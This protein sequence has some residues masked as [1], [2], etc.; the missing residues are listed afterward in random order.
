MQLK[1]SQIRRCWAVIFGCLLSCPATAC[2]ELLYFAT[3]QFVAYEGQTINGVLYRSSTAFGQVTRCIL[4]STNVIGIAPVNV[5]TDVTGLAG[6]GNPCYQPPYN[7]VPASFASGS[8]TANFAIG[9]VDNSLVQPERGA[10]LDVTFYGGNTNYIQ[11]AW[12]LL[13]DNDTPVTVGLGAGSVA[14]GRT[15]QIYFD[16]ATNNVRAPMTVRFTLSG[17]ATLNS[18]YQISAPAPFTLVTGATHQLTIP[19]WYTQGQG[20]VSVLSDAVLEGAETITVR[21]E[22]NP[23]QYTMPATQ[24]VTMVVRDDYPVVSV[25]ATDNYA[26][27]AG[28]NCGVFTL[29]RSGNLT[30]PVTVQVSYTGTAVPGS[31]YLALPT[32]ITF[33]AG[34]T[35]TN[36]VVTPI[37]DGLIEE[38]ETVVLNLLTN[39]SYVLGLHTNA[40]VTIAGQGPHPRD[41]YPRAE[42][43]M[44]GSGPNLDTYSIVVPLDGL[45]G[46]R[47]ADVETNQFNSRYATA[48]HYNATNAGNQAYITNRIKFDTPI[49]SFGS[50]WGAPLYL[51][52]SYSLG[53][54]AG[55]QTADPLR[56]YTL[57]RSNVAMAG[58]VELKLPNPLIASDWSN[59]ATNAFARTTNGYG[60]TTTLRAAANMTWGTS[61]GPGWLLT[62]TAT[63]AATNYVYLVAAVGLYNNQLMVLNESG[64]GA[65]G[66][67]YELTFEPRPAWRAVFIDQ[68]HFQTEPLPPD[69]WNKTPDE[70]YH[71]GAPVTNIVALSPSACTTLDHSPELRGHPIL[72][73]FVADL[74]NDPLALANYVQNEIELADPIAYRDDGSVTTESVNCGGVNRSAL[75]VYLEGQGSPVEQC[76]LLIYLLRRAGYPAAYVFPPEGG[77]KML[78]TRLSA[79]LRTRINQAQDKQ[80]RLYTRNRLITVNYPWVAV[81]ISNQWVHLFPWI[82]DTAV[83][84]GLNLYDYL[85]AQYKDM[86]LWVRDYILGRSNIMSFATLADDTPGVIFPRWLDHHL[87]QSAPGVS[88]DD[89]GIRYVNRR[90][91]Y[92]T[93]SDFPR[94]T[95]VSNFCIG[96]ESLTAAGI[97]NVSPRLTNIFDTVQVELYSVN[98]PDKK[99]ATC[100]MRMADLHNR[101]FFITHTN[102]GDGRVHAILTLAPYRP[103]ATN[104]IGNFAPTDTALTNKQVLTLV[105]TNTDDELKLRLRHRRQ[106]AL[107]WET[108]LDPDR[109][110]LDLRSERQ[111]L[112]ERPLRKGDVGGI[113]LNAGRVTP[114]MLRVHAQELWNMERLLSTNAAA[115]N[116]ISVDVYQG[117]LVYLVGMSYYERAARFDLP[118]RRLFKVQNLS[119]MAMGLA[120][121]SVRR[122]PDGT[123][124]SG[125]IDPIWPNVDMF[126]QEVAAVGNGTVRLD[127]GWDRYAAKRNYFNLSIA[128]LSAQEHAILNLFFGQSNAV[129]TVKLLQ[130]AQSK[131]PAGGSNVVELHYHNYAAEGNKVYAGKPLKDHD[132]AI[133]SEVVENFERGSS[134]GF[135]VAWVTPGSQTTP[136]GSFSGMGALILGTSRF[137]ALIGNNLYGG[138]ADRL[139]YGAVSPPQLPQW[140]VRGDAQGNYYF[141]YA[142]PTPS[143]RS[144]APAATATFDLTS[145]CALLNNG[146]FYVNPY[147]VQQGQLTGWLLNNAPGTYQGMYDDMADVGTLGKPSFI[148]RVWGTIADPVDTMTGEFHVD[149]VDLTLPGP[150]PLQVRRNYS[151]HNLAANQLGYG[152]KL[153]YMP[154]LTIANT[155]NIIYA[156]EPDGSVLASGP[157]A[158]NL[159]APT[160]ALNPTL[161]NDTVNGI[162]SV[163]NYFNARLARLVTPTNTFYYLT[164]GD[165][166]LR[167]FT[168]MSFPLTNSAA[169]DRSRPYLTSWFD[170]R[171]NFY[172]FEYGTNPAAADYGQVRR[173]IS[174][175]GNIVRF[176][177]DPYGRIVEA[178]SL[179]GRRVQY[180]DDRFGDLVRVTLPDTS[181]IKYEYELKT[182]STNNLTNVYSTHLLIRELKPDGRVLRN[183]FDHMR[184]VTNQWA[185]VG[186]DL[187]LVRNASFIYTNNFNLT[188]LTAALTG[189]TTVLDY[190]NNPTTYFYTNSLLRRVRDPLGGEL[191]QEWYEAGE[192]TPPAYPRSLKKVTDKRGLVTEYKYDSRGN[193][194]NITVRGDLRGDGNTDT[195]AVTTTV[196]NAN[197]LPTLTV[198]AAGTTNLFFYTN[199]WLLAWVEIWPSNATPAQ[200]V[201]NVYEYA[202]VTNA[203]D[204]TASFGLRVSEIRA[205]GSPDAATNEWTYSSRGFPIRFVRYTGTTDPAVVLTNL[206]NYR[207]ELVQQTDA[208]GRITR[209]GYDPLGRP[210]L[211]ELFEPGRSIP[212]AWGYSYYNENGEL[213][214]SD[215]PRF[216]PEDY[217]W[218]DYDGAGRKTVEIR[219]LTR[220]RPDGTGVQAETGDNLYA[221]TFNEYDP[222]G[223]LIR[224]TDPV[225]NYTRKRYDALGQLIREEFYDAT[226]VLLATNGFRYNPAGDVTNVFNPLGRLTEKQYTSTGK[227][228]FQRN[229]DGSTNAWRYYPD[230]RVHCEIQ[231][232]GAYWEYAYDDANRRVIRVFRSAAGVPLA[233]NVSEYDRR[234]N[235]IK[236]IDGLGNVFTSVYDGLDRLKSATGPAI[237]TVNEDCGLIPGCGNFVTNVLQQATTN[238]YDAAGVWLTN[239]NALCEKTVTRYDALGRVI[240]TEIRTGANALVRETTIVYHT[241]HHGMTVTNGAGATAIVTTTYTDNDGRPLLEVSYPVADSLEFTS[242]YY[243]RAGRRVESAEFCKI[244][245]GPPLVW[246]ISYWEYDGLNRVTRETTRDYATTTYEYDPMGNVTKRTMPGGLSWHA[247]YNVAG[248]LLEEKNVGTGGAATRTNTYAYYPAGHRWAGLLQTRAD[249]RG[250][251]C[252]H[253]YDDWLRQ[254]T[255]AYTGPLPE[256]NLTTTWQY[257]LRGLLTN[258]VQLFANTNVSP[259]TVVR[260][261]YDPYGQMHTECI[262][263]GQTT[264]AGAAMAY[265]AAGRHSQLRLDTHSS[266]A[267]YSYG[268]RADGALV[269]VI[270]PAGTAVYTYDTAGLLTSRSIA[271]RTASVTARDGTGRPY[272]IRTTIGATTVLAESLSWYLNGQLAAHTLARADYT[273]ARAYDYA[274]LS[275]R[276]IQE[277]LNLSATV[278]WTNYF[279]YDNA[280][281]AGPGVLT[282]IGGSGHTSTAWTGSPDAFC[283]INFETNTVLRRTAYGTVNGPATVTATLD[284]QPVGI[285][286]LGTNGGQWRA[287]LALTPGA[288]QLVVTARH[289]SGQFTTN[290]VSWF[291]NNNTAGDRAQVYYDALGQPTLRVW[292]AAN[293][294][295]NRT[296]TLCWDVTG[297]LWKVIERDSANNGYDWQA[298][299]DAFGRRLQTLTVTV[300]NGVA[301]GAAPR[302]IFS[303]YDPLVEFLE[304][305]VQYDTGIIGQGTQTAWKLYGPDLSGRYGGL[306]GVGGLEAVKPGY[307]APVV[308]IADALGN[309]HKQFDTASGTL[310]LSSVRPTAYGA[311][312][313]REPVALGY[314]GT[315]LDNLAWRGRWKDITGLYWLGMRYYEPESGRWLSFDPVWNLADASGYSFCGGD[316]INRFDADGRVGKAVGDFVY[317]GGAAGYALREIGLYVER[318]E[319]TS[320]A[321]GWWTGLSSAFAY[322][323]AAASAPSTYVSGLRS[324]G[325]NVASYYQDFGLL[326]AASYALTSWNVG[327]VYSG[328]ANF[329]LRYETAG[330]PIGDWYERG[331]VISSGVAS[332]A[333]IAA[334]AL[335]GCGV[336]AEGSARPPVPAKFFARTRIEVEALMEQGF[337]R[338]EAFQHIRAFNA[339][340][341]EGFLFHFTDEIGGLGIIR[342]GE[343]QATQR[344]LGGPGVYTG[345]TPTPNFFQRYGSP[346]GWG[347]NPSSNVRIPI[348]VTPEIEAITRTP[349]LPRWTRIIGEG[350][351]MP[352]PRRNP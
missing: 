181:Q 139:N 173:M 207:G 261:S 11:Q 57:Y 184:R 137:A 150:M 237:V 154:F 149:E 211:R 183:E 3:N 325:Y 170:N 253:Y 258:S 169:W 16:R 336:P 213:T 153:N 44:R 120:K 284:G 178:Y 346:I 30:R 330:Q 1:A 256:H 187:R 112:V 335:G 190:T 162:G 224:V 198:D 337:S 201:T 79:L 49:A 342:S 68:P 296:Q 278:R 37:A 145:D 35:K 91:L 186:P 333:G 266:T 2:G 155:N 122:N 348:I 42:R 55:A 196:Y 81:Y 323:L 293:G 124:Y 56:I 25:G 36:L 260:R 295:T 135:V 141:T 134:E 265:D 108:A 93:W 9:V 104:S 98:N 350:E 270:G 340:E 223:N 329:D 129:S 113:C 41:A 132:P 24:A 232:N 73:Q 347:L 352:L 18:D 179:D 238:F 327:A 248:Q 34:Q 321:A 217:V 195:T 234:G 85:P 109:G 291:T 125:P 282:G 136:S 314:G 240:R 255:N 100:E 87:K 114:A 345:T 63:D 62:H 222:F 310:T 17:S 89:I 26:A 185:T 14:E 77:L 267:N 268:W 230:G 45:K 251:T 331:A 72:D 151:S 280:T 218:R 128:D 20:N 67:L 50:R 318:Y 118:L 102:I 32:N 6:F 241:N 231:R 220:A 317:Q 29:T 156:A 71:F 245:D 107:N 168:V 324:Y 110:F 60:L 127:S 66:Y 250:V 239:V 76:A 244:G 285:S 105:L 121:L 322:Q 311:V 65:Y 326:P 144:F 70:L 52:Q 83:E 229:P 133:W 7:T 274:V 95:W 106:R 200:A 316:P 215:G 219:W 119:S 301:P 199:T 123:L 88:L 319:N 309:A 288:H 75:G 131:V 203:A 182:W 116:T 228:K 235:L 193:V 97:T 192:T 126:F 308:F 294:T 249:G 246:S 287:P 148:R 143:Q 242:Y 157:I 28:T 344:G 259:T 165:G 147:Q 160:P 80:G 166:S 205:A 180:E 152:W 22:P 307:A 254:A 225:G 221:T 159:W 292:R 31:D 277:R 130:L 175:S 53:I 214:W 257:D 302:S 299:Y 227:L 209:F 82:K 315:L 306:Q 86:Q 48:Y 332:R 92:A 341:A 61:I 297:R 272:E 69:L 84:E 174:S 21:I 298:T 58:F 276:L 140:E 177:Y 164:N 51:G 263:L 269:S 8:L 59:F 27:E 146:S 188:N 103:D 13:Q 313:G 74:N 33:A 19:A 349:L 281:P 90:H 300:S 15:N 189:T 264:L 38:A 275:R 252:V 273:D 191:V 142:D 197:N 94:P 312:P 243:D 338:A 202:N 117:S 194:T 46:T 4:V 163:A 204:G 40:V 115:T 320:G 172:R 262:S 339:G 99:I 279:T 176:S 328:V 96:V 289:P 304:L 43:Y 78:D 286:L 216:D 10:V 343:I 12:I 283:R 47:R 290:A 64:G 206:Y 247:R 334:G 161:N 5:A 138:Y 271:G 226:G 208:A 305:G 167:V 158:T 23:V 111:V 236:T 212:L 101:K 54:H 171:G 39:Q 233:T 303:W 351:N 210:Q